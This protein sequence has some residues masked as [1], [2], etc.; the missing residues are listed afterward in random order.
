MTDAPLPY[1]AG[2][3]ERRLSFEDVDQHFHLRIRSL[4]GLC[5]P[6][7]F[8]DLERRFDLAGMRRAGII[9]VMYYLEFETFPQ[10]LVFF[11]RVRM[12]YELRLRRS[13][14]EGPGGN[15]AGRVERLLLDMHIAVSGQQGRGDPL[16]LRPGGEGEM[17]PAGRLRAVHVITRPVA[18]PGERQVLVVPEALRALQEHPWDEPMPSI[19]RLSTVPPTL[20][21]RETGPWQEQR[22][23][24]GLHNTDVNQHVNV[25]EY[26]DALANHGA[27]L[28]YG[29]NL[30][31]ARHRVARMDMLFRR[32]FF[33]GDAHAAR[34][35]LY[36][37]DYR[38]VVLA[39]LH[40]AEPEGGLDPRASVFARMEG[41]IAPAG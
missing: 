19:E 3:G 24:W 8:G 30:P 31:V 25:H 16:D 4:I 36:T 9:P 21:E 5:M 26:I 7:V 6:P 39:G 18:P 22:S 15:P 40:A 33:I 34:G 2:S 41:S 1:L 35:H 11:G 12:D 10:P 23:V 20:P 14:I 13:V 38:T 28:L 27:R 17:V 37:D 32:P 29:S